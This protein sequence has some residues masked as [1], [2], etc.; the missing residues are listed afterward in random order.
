MNIALYVIV[1]C[2]WGTSWYAIIFQVANTPAEH[3]VLY[4]FAIASIVMMA[5]AAWRGERMRF[6]AREHGMIALMGL[7]L[8]SLNYLF[9]YNA[10][11]AGMTTG[12]AAVV[13]STAVIMN[14]ANERLWL[15]NRTDARMLLA[16]GFGTGGITIV[17]WRDISAFDM[18]EP[19]SIAVVLC[20][21]GTYL[22]SSGNMVS[23]RL[24]ARRLPLISSLGFAMIYGTLFLL[25]VALVGE[26]PMDF[27]A[28][29][30]F[31]ATLLFLALF[32]TVIGFASYL[33]LLGRIGA[34]RASY[35]T[36]LFPVIAL[37]LSTLFEGYAWTPWALVG[38]A[39][40]LA[41][42]VIVLSRPAKSGGIATDQ[43]PT[44]PRPGS[45]AGNRYPGS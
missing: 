5:W 26:A 20:I 19:T 6:S 17:F 24:Q 35:A 42:N 41:G 23:A 30:E 18:S 22:F 33:S 11:A 27:D 36:V 28:S 15:G 7:C 31:V 3:S 16:V 1:V 25:L 38:V 34:A 4:R 37:A 45:I 44:R 14:L 2:V 40:I 32:S 9:F 29:F 12:L 8:F 39:M 21:A 43:N 10:T 13:F